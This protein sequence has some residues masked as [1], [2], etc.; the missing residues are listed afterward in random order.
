MSGWSYYCYVPALP[1][2]VSTNTHV[3][4]TS[5]FLFWNRGDF[6]LC[7]EQ[8]LF[9]AVPYAVLALVSAL[10]SGLFWSPTKRK[11]LVPVLVAR[12]I[13]VSLLLLNVIVS[14]VS[15]FW[16]ATAQPYSIIVSHCAHVLAWLLHLLC[17][18]SMGRSFYHRGRGPLPLHLTWAL[19]LLSS[20][21]HFR[22]VV[23]YVSHKTDFG[24][25]QHS[26]SYLPVVFQVTSYIQFGLQLLYMCTLAFPVPPTTGRR[27]VITGS[28]QYHGERDTLLNKSST[29]V[30]SDAIRDYGAVPMQQEGPPDPLEGKAN[31]LSLLS[32]WWLQSVMKRGSLGHIQQPRD[33][34]FMPQALHTATVRERFQR[35][36]N[37]NRDYLRAA[38]DEQALR[39]LD[40]L[41]QYSSQSDV[42]YAAMDTPQSPLLAQDAV[43]T[44]PKRQSRGPVSLLRALNRSFGVQYYCLGLMKLTSDCL[45][46]AGPLLLHQLVAFMENRNVSSI[47]H[48]VCSMCVRERMCVNACACVHVFVCLWCMWV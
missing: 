13:I 11:A 22:L 24:Q 25:D 29:V 1:D 17:I 37:R 48:C 21:V 7:S 14:L 28:T 6:G 30:S 12:G 39:S 15:S 38:P 10:Y 23:R 36:L 5:T 35:A 32:F 33:L 27:L 8:L 9:Q 45:G 34:P 43:D 40:R 46:F 18:I 19:T 41:S 44:A 16:L 20:I 4:S 47:S 26:T 2:D 3:P 42:D 31:I